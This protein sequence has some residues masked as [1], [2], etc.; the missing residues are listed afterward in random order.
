MEPIIRV[1]SVRIEPSMAT[2]AEKTKTWKKDLE[3]VENYTYD[4]G[5]WLIAIFPMV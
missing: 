3:L 2:K 5:R 1:V 4:A